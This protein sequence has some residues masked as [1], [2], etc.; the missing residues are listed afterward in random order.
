MPSFAS[1]QPGKNGSFLGSLKGKLVLAILLVVTATGV[2]YNMGNRPHAPAPTPAATTT[3]DDAAGPSIM[4]GEGGWVQSWAGDTNGSHAGRQITIY[5][6]S[7]KLS[8]YRIEFQGEI[9][10]KSIGWVFRALDPYNYYAMKL[11]IVTPGLS[12]KMALIK[13]VV[14]QGHETEVGRVPLDMAVRND[15]LF[16]VRMD[17]RGS[18]FST[19]VQG[20]PVDVWTDEQIKSGGVGFLNERAERARVKSAAISYLTGGKN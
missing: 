9:D 13:Y 7:L 15:T 12:P 14:L 5:R 17:V 2:F 8:D 3:T 18:K 19:F 4:M 10:S 6:P 11:S 1:I 20:Q 16:S